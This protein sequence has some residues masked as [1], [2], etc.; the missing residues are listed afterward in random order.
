M[1]LLPQIRISRASAKCAGACRAGAAVGA[2][3]RLG[4]GAGADGAIQAARRRAGSRSGRP[5]SRPAAG[6]WCRRSC[7]AGWPACPSMALKR[8]AISRSASLQPMR[9]KRAPRPS[10]APGAA[11]GAGARG[12]GCARRSGSPWCTARHGC[13]GGPGDP[14]TLTTRHPAR[15][16]CS[17]QVSGQSCGQAPLTIRLG[18]MG[19]KGG[20]RAAP[21]PRRPLGGWRPQGD[22]G[23][24]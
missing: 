22:W 20:R 8:A 14:T 10:S 24:A 12:G 16:T 7:R 17:A 4:A 6:P 19:E 13:W 11:G 18:F 21:R 2:V 9:S 23:Q 15:W 1:R 3:E 5:S